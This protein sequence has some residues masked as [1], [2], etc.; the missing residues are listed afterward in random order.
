MKPRVPL[1]LI[2]GLALLLGLMLPAAAVQART[3]KNVSGPKKVGEVPECGGGRPDQCRID[4][5]VRQGSP[6]TGA[7]CDSFDRSEG[8]CIGSSSGTSAFAQP[9]FFPRQGLSTDFTW[10]G[11]NPRDVDYTV[12]AQFTIVQ[13][14]IVGNVP[15]GGSATFNVTDAWSRAS[16]VHYK[17][18][19][20]GGNPGQPGGPLYIDYSHEFV[21][22]YVHMFGYLVPKK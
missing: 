8:F 22:S 9:G 1:Q 2:A 12:N 6:T 4:V 18:V 7:S 13:A 3:T 5:Y 21:G 17:T 16:D 14:K 20:T 10:K 15:S 19:S 11:G